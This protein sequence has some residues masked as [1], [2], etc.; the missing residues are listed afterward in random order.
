MP[1]SDP[2]QSAD[3]AR[4]LIE[5]VLAWRAN[6]RRE[7]PWDPAVQRALET[8]HDLAPALLRLLLSDHAPDGRAQQTP[9]AGYGVCLALLGEALTRIRYAVERQ[10]PW[11]ADM[12]EQV[13]QDIAQL[14]FKPEVD[15]RVQQDLI[16]TLHEAKLP[17]HPCIRDQAAELSAYYAR[18]QGARGPA[19]LDTLLERLARETAT[20]DPFA[21]LE[22]LLAQMTVMPAEAQVMMA[23]GMMASRQPQLNELGLLLLLHPEAP[24]R[25]Q[26]P[27]A[28]RQT[29]A[30]GRVGALGLRRLIGL[31]NWLPADERPAVDAL[32]REVRLAG[33][34]PAPL[35]PVQA[36]RVYA[37]AFDGSGAQAVWTFVKEKRHYR[38][39][40]VL[41]KQGVGIREVWG[42]GGFTKR[43]MDDRIRQMTG[44][45]AAVPVAGD[46]VPPLVAHFIAVGLDRLTPPPAQLLALNELAGGDY[47]KPQPLPP[48]DAMA[49]LAATDPGAFTPKRVQQVL[50]QSRDWPERHAFAASWFEDDARIDDLLRS[51]VGPPAD[52]IAQ[53]PAAAAA[54]VEQVLEE[55]RGPWAE[56]LLWMARWAQ[57][58][59][60]RTPVTW[61]EFLIVA[62]ELVQGR[63]LAQVPLMQTIAVRSVQSAWRRAGGR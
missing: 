49:D 57:A 16:A 34:A 24:V 55:R 54:V 43:E 3:S 2:P 5:A 63:T 23:T 47:W 37:S 56:R 30:A 50:A 15:V 42:E 59:Q 39:T 31:R 46:Y 21:L 35:A 20:D 53:L 11:A 40:A 14:A 52:W 25:T 10:R 8:D 44:N 27:D 28:Y 29:G 33:V 19:D 1:T 4:Q 32:I 45:G 36:L 18:F 6:P 22:A 13:Q 58:T 38:I 48:A 62:Q 7:Q 12:A 51:R 60:G 26:L 61:Q 41:V 9:T 17:L